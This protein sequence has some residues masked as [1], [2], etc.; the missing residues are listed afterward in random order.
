MTRRLAFVPVF[1]V[2]FA[3]LGSGTAA[4]SSPN[5][6]FGYHVGDNLLQ[7]IGAPAGVVAMADNGDT[8]K[9]IATGTFDLATKAADGGGTFEHRAPDGS[10][11]GKGTL[12]ASK[13]ITFQL[14]GC[15]GAGIPPNFC[16]G[17]ASLAVQLHPASNPNLS[18][19]AILEVNCGIGAPPPTARVDDFIRL[20]IQDLINFNKPVSG[21]VTV[22]NKI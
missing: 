9:V 15:G 5:G 16:G 8:V 3:F 13:L 18:I 20:N 21:G 6:A 17:R 12:T 22:F 19:D 11:R 14:Y 2:I 4:A 1:L 7:G 10:L